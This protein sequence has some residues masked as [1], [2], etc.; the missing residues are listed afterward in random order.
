M[1][2]TETRTAAGLPGMSGIST[3]PPVR[4]LVAVVVT[5]IAILGTVLI[6]F[7]LTPSGDRGTLINRLGTA[8]PLIVASI[9]AVLAYLKT[10]ENSSFIAV[11]SAKVDSVAENVNSRMS[12]LID[13]KTTPSDGTT[14]ALPDTHSAPSPLINPS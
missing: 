1:S 9:P 4:V 3:A 8:I 7:A 13:A 5:A 2:T 14:A 10:R 11:T 12:T 6:V